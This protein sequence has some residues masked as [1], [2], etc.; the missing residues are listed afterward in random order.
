MSNGN[1]AISHLRQVPLEPD[2][3]HRDH[4]PHRRGQDHH[5]RAHPLLHRPQL[6]DRRGPRGRR[7]R[8]TGWS[9]SRSAASPS[10]RAAT[11]CH[12]AAT[13]GSTSSTRRATSTSRSR[14]S[15]SLR[16]LD[17]AVAVFDGVAG[18][19]PQT[20]T[21]WRQANKYGVPRMC[22]INKMDRARRRLLRGARHRSRTGSAPTS[23]SSSSRSAPRATSR[24]VID[25]VTMKALVW[26][27]E[28]LGAELGRP[29]DPGRARGPGRGV[30]PRSSSTCCRQLRREHPREVRRRGGDH[31][32]TTSAGAIRA[33]TIAG[34]IVP[35]SAA[36]R[37]RTRACSPCS[38]PSST[39][40][41]A[42]STCRRSRA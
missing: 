34:E 18:V 2:P 32:P 12:V 26:Q 13:T 31:R 1:A 17:G 21:V 41:P 40:C 36:P 29:G 24:G 8:W 37:S 11:T 25:L 27:D 14:S 15:A 19:E 5:D 7:R 3:K 28:E 4:G 42:R 23:P 33:G 16:V 10:P 35:C 38:T 20:E 9:R 39:T 22:F 6:Q 30:P